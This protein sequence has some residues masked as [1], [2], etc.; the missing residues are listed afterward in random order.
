MKKLIGVRY[1]TKT[2]KVWFTDI[3]A[4]TISHQERLGEALNYYRVPACLLQI[5]QVNKVP[6]F[7]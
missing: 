6:L 3:M 7:Y 4:N 1:N 2:N 5:G